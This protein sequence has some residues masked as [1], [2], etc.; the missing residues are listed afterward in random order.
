MSGIPVQ[1]WTEHLL[2]GLGQWLAEQ[3]VA[4]YG[5]SGEFPAEPQGKPPLALNG[6]PARPDVAYSVTAYPVDDDPFLSDSVVGLQ[7]ISRGTEDRRTALAL[8]DAVFN[9]LHGARNLT[10]GGVPVVV[11]A[12]RSSTS[13]GQDGNRRWELVSN[14]W[15]TAARPTLHRVD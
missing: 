2:D 10:W 1:D 4:R 5:S 3:G 6:M 14:Y 15:A 13:L 12:R 8:D 11:V 7:V 9:V